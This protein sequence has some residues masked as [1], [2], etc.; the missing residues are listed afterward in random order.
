MTK[1]EDIIRRGKIEPNGNQYILKHNRAIKSLYTWCETEAAKKA[2]IR[3]V[4][5][6]K[7]SFWAKNRLL[8]KDINQI[9]RI[10]DEGVEKEITEAINESWG[11]SEK[12]FDT[13]I[14]EF[15]EPVQLR[16]EWFKKNPA[17]LNAFINRS[18]NGLRLSGRIWKQTQQAKKM[19]E[20]SLASGIT[21]GMPSAKISTVLREALREPEKLFRR[22]RD[23]KTGKLMLSKAAKLYHPGPGVYRS[24]YKNAFRLCATE[25]N[26][27]YRF[28]EFERRQKVPFVTGYRVVLSNAHPQLDICDNM[29]GRYPKTFH[30][31]GWHPWC[32]CYVVPILLNKKDFMKYTN[33]GVIQSNKYINKVPA[34]ATNYINQYGDRFMGYQNKPY[35]MDNFKKVK[36]NNFIWKPYAN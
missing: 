5:Y 28:A 17:A 12:V 13:Q 6:S 15:A 7:H 10:L 26:F 21:Q 22:V 34:K 23:K 3:N 30:F 20:I 9:L 25:T 4:T 35:F 19:I 36:K 27:A 14:K 18:V 1:P 24:S 11:K 29:A 8:E 31:M 2:A 32:I 33:T 16:T